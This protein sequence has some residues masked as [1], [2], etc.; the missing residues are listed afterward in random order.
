[1]GHSCRE[2]PDDDPET[3][4]P[5]EWF[6]KEVNADGK[7]CDDEVMDLWCDKLH[8]DKIDAEESRADYFAQIRKD[9]Q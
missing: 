1:M 5:P 7:L 2:S 6:K 3:S 9:E 8:Q 4:E